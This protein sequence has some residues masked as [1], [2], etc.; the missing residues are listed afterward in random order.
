[1][2]Q[3]DR[4]APAIAAELRRR[5]AR[6]KQH[7]DEILS[8]VMKSDPYALPPLLT[9]QQ[10]QQRQEGPAQQ[11][12]VRLDQ[13]RARKKAKESGRTLQKRVVTA[14]TADGAEPKHLLA[15]A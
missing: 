9:L 14:Q 1:M 11:K 6:A 12:I 13:E 3:A 15:E 2:H 10:E 8:M 4:T 7:C 5:R